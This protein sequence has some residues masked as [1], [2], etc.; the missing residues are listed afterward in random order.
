MPCDAHCQR[1]ISRSTCMG[2]GSHRVRYKV[3]IDARRWRG[4]SHPSVRSVSP[5]ARVAS[6][7]GAS[8]KPSRDRDGRNAAIRLLAAP[9]VLPGE[10]TSSIVTRTCRVS[11][12]PMP[13]ENVLVG[14]PY[15]VR[16]SASYRETSTNQPA[17]WEVAARPTTATS[18]T[19][20]SLQTLPRLLR[21]HRSDASS[22]SPPIARSTSVFQFVS[23]LP[24]LFSTHSLSSRRPRCIAN[25]AETLAA[26]SRA[27]AYHLFA[28]LID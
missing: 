8:S 13:Q 9:R 11:I 27:A 10:K 25:A 26:A 19:R 1:W 28:A 16:G 18:H 17:F 20:A 7:P 21:I 24:L 2:W 15:V 3:P 23:R 4:G 6:A 12:Q 5:C 14:A 22:S